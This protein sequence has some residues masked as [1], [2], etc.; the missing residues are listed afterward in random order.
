M[1]WYLTG[2]FMVSRRL[3]TQRLQLT[4]LLPQVSVILIGAS[5]AVYLASVVCGFSSC[6][7][8][9]QASLI[10]SAV[11]PSPSPEHIG[12]YL[13]SSHSFWLAM[14]FVWTLLHQAGQCRHSLQ[15]RFS[16]T[17]WICLTVVL[18]LAL[19]FGL[20]SFRHSSSPL[21]SIFYRDG[22]L[23]LMVLVGAL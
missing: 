21:L 18:A 9:L 14:I 11:A 17:Q 3:C 7:V 13:E 8:C 4:Q 1:G 5:A 20:A 19:W 10:W 2:L 23:Y 22:T 12:C 16:K 15:R 6:L